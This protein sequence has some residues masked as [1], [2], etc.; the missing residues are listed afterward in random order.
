M[1]QKPSQ[2]LRLPE[3]D[4]LENSRKKDNFQTMK[5]L[6]FLKNSM[7]QRTQRTQ[8]L[9]PQHSLKESPKY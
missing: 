6:H 2:E 5:N 9:L 8:L 1:I 4:K 3:Q 7:L